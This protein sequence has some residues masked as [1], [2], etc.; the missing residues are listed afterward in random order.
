MHSLAWSREFQEAALWSHNARIP[1]IGKSLISLPPCQRPATYPSEMQ[2]CD[3]AL[4]S[5]HMKNKV[6]VEGQPKRVKAWLYTGSA[7]ANEE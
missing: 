5:K 7:A 2:N 6:K 4:E 3:G 1:R